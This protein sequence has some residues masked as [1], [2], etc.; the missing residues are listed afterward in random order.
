MV[1]ALAEV[2][3][4][5][6][7]G[8]GLLGKIRVRVRVRVRV[9]VRIRAR[10]KVRVVRVRANLGHRLVD[11]LLGHALEARSQ[12]LRHREE[13]D[14]E[15]HLGV[16]HLELRVGAHGSLA[17]EELL[18]GELER[19]QLVPLWVGVVPAGPLPLLQ[20]FLVR[21]PGWVITSSEPILVTK[22]KERGDRNTVQRVRVRLRL[23]GMRRVNRSL[24]DRCELP[25]RPITAQVA[26]G[27]ASHGGLHA[28]RRCVHVGLIDG[29]SGHRRRVVGQYL[30][31]HHSAVLLANTRRRGCYQLN[32]KPRSR[33]GALNRSRVL[34]P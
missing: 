9:K 21:H 17:L 26:H 16:L 5:L 33:A 24:A 18:D 14:P 8:L 23:T 7:L 6:A 27:A 2:R 19:A 31:R 25:V 32:S 20:G 11:L 1:H 3:G 34:V 10:V 29:T 12:W 28:G 15:E 13:V 30:G 4:L 22:A